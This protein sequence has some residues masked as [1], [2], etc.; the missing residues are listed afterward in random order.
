VIYEHPLAY[1]LGLEGTALLRAFIGEYDR[2]FVEARIREIRR[3]LS[4]EP[5]ARAA[6]E[7]ERVNT[8]DGYRTWAT[9]YDQPGN[10]AFALDQPIVEEIIETLPAGTA[11]DAACGTGR[12]AQLLAERGHRV[13]GVDSSPDMLE[14]ARVRVPEGEF[15]LGELSRLPIDD[16]AVDLV[17]CSLALAHIRVL[18]PVFAEFA[19]V[20]R[21]GGYLVISDMHPEAIARGSIPSVRSSDGRPSRVVCYR[22]ALGDY[23][24][25]ALAVGL[26]LRRC[27]EPG[28]STPEPA[29]LDPAPELTVGPWDLW[30]WSLHRLVPEAARAANSGTPGLIL[31]HFQQPGS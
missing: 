23:L 6:V 13:I 3:L 8:V 28:V 5:L 30:P 21:P 24:R 12:F 18:E 20:L 19:R 2:E 27:A 4:D 16:Q 7:V 26:Q 9:T 14:R 10:P 31:W 25:A 22:H 17:V 29:Q 11:L 1:L 15:L